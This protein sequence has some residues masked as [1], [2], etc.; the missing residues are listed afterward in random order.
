MGRKKLDAPKP[1]DHGRVTVINLKGSMA[2]RE[3]LAGVSA[4]THIPASTIARLA[5]AEW[6]K[7]NRHSAPPE[8]G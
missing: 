8:G 1:D 3:W 5:F 4:K 6:A 7:R 2:M